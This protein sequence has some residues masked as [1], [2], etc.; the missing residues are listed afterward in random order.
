[1]WCLE[2]EAP[3]NFTQEGGDVATAR[4]DA[5]EPVPAVAV[6]ITIASSLG[7]DEACCDRA[8]QRPQ[9]SCETYGKIQVEG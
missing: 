2:A 6:A 8:V 7:S 4:L 9:C 5:Q 3:A 1:M